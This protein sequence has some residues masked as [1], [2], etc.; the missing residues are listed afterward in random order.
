[1]RAAAGAGFV[2]IRASAE[3]DPKTVLAGGER[4]GPIASGCYPLSNRKLLDAKSTRGSGGGVLDSCKDRESF[5]E[6]GVESGRYGRLGGSPRTVPGESQE[7]RR[8]T[9]TFYRTSCVGG[10]AP[11][12]HSCPWRKILAASRS[13][14]T[15]AGSLMRRAV[16][17]ASAAHLA[18]LPARDALPR[19]R[20]RLA[21]LTAMT[22]AM[23]SA[24]T[25]RQ[26]CSPKILR[27]PSRQV[28]LPLVESSSASS[29]SD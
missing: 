29:T 25:W 11:R 8:I 10:G 16:L 28:L 18:P 23:A 19:L 3:V 26:H 21:L 22:A 6:Y 9:S 12:Q 15:S 4:D 20:R 5:C 27:R 2:Q 7:R 1:M 17:P 14:A 24:T 13:L